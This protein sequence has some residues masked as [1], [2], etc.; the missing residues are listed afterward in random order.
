MVADSTFV[1]TDHQCRVMRSKFGLEI[2][3]DI[4]NGIL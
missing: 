2:I 4:M 3:V 1:F